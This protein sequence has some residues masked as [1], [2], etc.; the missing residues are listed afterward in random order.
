MWFKWNNA[1]NADSDSVTS[2]QNHHCVI[3]FAG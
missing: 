3:D 1:S 2:L